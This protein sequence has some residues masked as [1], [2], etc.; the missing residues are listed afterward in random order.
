MVK[1][2][3]GFFI[4]KRDLKD[5]NIFFWTSSKLSKVNFPGICNLTP[6]N[7]TAFRDTIRN[8]GRDKT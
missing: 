2:V 6:C 3:I 4:K 7:L 1:L 8:I 5:T